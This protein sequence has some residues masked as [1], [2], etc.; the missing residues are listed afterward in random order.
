MGVHDGLGRGMATGPFRTVAASPKL[1]LGRVFGGHAGYQRQWGGFIAGID[2][3]YSGLPTSTV[4]PR[5][6]RR[7]LRNTAIDNLL[8]ANGRLGYAS[9]ARLM[10]YATGGWARSTIDGQRFAAS[11]DRHVSGW[12]VGGGYEYMIAPN[13]TVGFEY[14][15]VDYN[16]ET[17]GLTGGDSVDVDADLDVVKAR[18]TVRLARE[19]W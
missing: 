15:H 9:R 18:L 19:R 13:V 8:L 16:D 4:T 14:I 6:A 12:D 2:I 3:S 7:P 17:F 10:V 11:D 1:D 5:A